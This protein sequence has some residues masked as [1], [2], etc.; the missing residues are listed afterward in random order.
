MSQQPA[1]KQD[2]TDEANTDS[3]EP[4]EDVHRSVESDDYKMSKDPECATTPEQ[5]EDLRRSAQSDD[6]DGKAMH[7]GFEQQEVPVAAHNLTT[8]MTMWR[9]AAQHHMRRATALNH[10]NTTS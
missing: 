9:A 2:W 7:D 4:K 8:R 10:W 6:E 1:E 5:Q 3:H